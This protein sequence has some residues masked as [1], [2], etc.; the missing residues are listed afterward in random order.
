MEEDSFAMFGMNVSVGYILVM[1]Q[2]GR[3]VQA[4]NW[5]LIHLPLAGLISAKSYVEYFK[6]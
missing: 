2:A 3:D 4:A 1:Q 5:Y 6:F